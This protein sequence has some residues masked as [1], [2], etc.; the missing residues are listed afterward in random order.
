MAAAFAFLAW[1]PDARAADPSPLDD[2]PSNVED[3]FTGHNLIFHGTAILA[4]GVMAESG[5]DH[6]I[7]VGFQKSLVFPAYADTAYYAGYA[8][9][10]VVAPALYLVGL[11]ADDRETVGAGSAAIQALG[12]TLATTGLLKWGTGRAYP[13]NGGDPNAPDRLEHPE[14][15]HR[16]TPFRAG[17]AWPS[18][19][20]S[21]TISIAAALTAYYP[22]RVAIPLVGYPLAL[23]IGVGMVA[24]DRHWASDVVAGALIGHAIGF[25]VGRNFRRSVRSAD[26]IHITPLASGGLGIS[27][28]GVF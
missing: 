12:V 9:P 19:H 8:I 16:F 7:R 22:E 13:L 2:L 25:S 23:A 28:G 17:L 10:A 11:F 24:G 21:A 18:G 15:A 5:A 26:R 3:A 1:E 4:T 27:A 20:T 14:Y 6:A